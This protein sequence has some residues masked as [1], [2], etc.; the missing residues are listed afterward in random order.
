MST[1]KLVFSL[2]AGAITLGGCATVTRGMS[3]QVNFTSEPSGAAVRTSI[4]LACP[5]TPCTFDISRKSA[6][7]AIFTLP[8]Y[9]QQEINVTTDVA[10]N[11]AAGFAGNILLGGLIGMGTDVATGATL[12]HTPNPVNALMVPIPTETKPGPRIRKPKPT[13]VS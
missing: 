1:L 4:G 8:G 5:A 7:T 11:G 10:G 6:F 9:V 2:I 13:P 12:N 3:E